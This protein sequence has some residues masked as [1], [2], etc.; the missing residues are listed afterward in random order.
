MIGYLKQRL[1]LQERLQ[2][3]STGTDR[4]LG[5]AVRIIF[6][7]GGPGPDFDKDRDCIPQKRPTAR[8]EAVTKP[9]EPVRNAH[10][11]PAIRP[12]WDNRLTLKQ[13]L[14]AL[15]LKYLDNLPKGGCLWVIG[16]QEL[17]QVM[18]DLRRGGIDFAFK[19][20]PKATGRR[21]AWW[22]KNC[23]SNP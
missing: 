6:E 9:I 10:S 4:A 3:H 19:P 16:G 5:G 2:G 8:G 22:T 13:T 17:K 20:C 12:P 18:D 21:P 1:K 15:G 23:P 14:S 11:D 7:N